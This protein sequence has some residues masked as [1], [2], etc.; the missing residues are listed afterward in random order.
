M[1]WNSWFEASI[2]VPNQKELWPL[3]LWVKSITASSQDFMKATNPNYDKNLPQYTVI[4]AATA[5]ILI[6]FLFFIKKLEKGM[7]MGGVK[8]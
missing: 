3:Q 1:K 2:Y 7:A 4:V 5:P 8:G 6:A